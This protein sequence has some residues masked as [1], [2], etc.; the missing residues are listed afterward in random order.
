MVTLGF[1]GLTRDCTHLEIFD[2]AFVISAD[3]F[4][5][6]PTHDFVHWVHGLMQGRVGKQLQ[7]PY[8]LLDVFGV[9]V[10]WDSMSVVRGLHIHHLN[11]PTFHCSYIL[12]ATIRGVAKY[13]DGGPIEGYIS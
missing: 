12:D 3:A 6:L 11:T 2:A 4:I 1:M 10:F 8:C 7:S 5:D 13:S 9:F